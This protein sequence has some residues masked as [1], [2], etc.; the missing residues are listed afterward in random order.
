MCPSAW[1]AKESFLFI[2]QVEYWFAVTEAMDKQVEEG[3]AV[4]LEAQRFSTVRGMIAITF[5][6]CF[7]VVTREVEGALCEKR[8]LVR[9]C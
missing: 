8:S 3:L 5:A 6:L 2:E 1:Q 4:G 7:I 9:Y